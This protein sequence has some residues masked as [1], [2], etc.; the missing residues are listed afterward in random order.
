MDIENYDMF[1]SQRNET[2]TN[3]LTVESYQDQIDE[4]TS[5]NYFI[6]NPPLLWKL[7]ITKTNIGNIYFFRMR[8]R[9]LY[10]IVKHGYDCT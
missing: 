3:Y 5:Q 1:M 4:T 9:V 10:S 8:A 2:T 6:L 7:Y